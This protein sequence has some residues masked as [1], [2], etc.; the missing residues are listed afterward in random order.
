VK[1]LVCVETVI[2]VHIP[3][4]F[5]V[6]SGFVNM[7]VMDCWCQLSAFCMVE[8][9]SDIAVTHLSF[10]LIIIFEL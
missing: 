1:Q 3:G 10:A 8:L 2:C 6:L 9:Q 5:P 4:T 7:N